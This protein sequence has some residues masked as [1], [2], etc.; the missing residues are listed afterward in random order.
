MDSMTGFATRRGGNGVFEWT[1]DLRSVNGKGL[2]LRLRVPD[3]VTGL[4]QGLRKKLQSALARGSVQ[5]S[6][7]VSK[8]AAD[9]P[10]VLDHTALE[11]IFA[12]STL[13][14]AEAGKRDIPIAPLSV[15]EIWGRLGTSDTNLNE[16]QVKALLARLLADADGLIADLKAMRSTEGA[17]LQGILSGQLDQ[18]TTLMD[19]ARTSLGGRKEEQAQILH[20]ALARLETTNVEPD[21]LA[22]ELALLAV[23]SDV[24]EELDRLDGHVAAARDMVSKNQ[25]VGRKLDFLM[26]EFNRE[27]NTLCSKSANGPLTQTG[28]EMKVLVDQMREQIQN[29]E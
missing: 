21:R 10:A 19:A 14:Q 7:R 28:L 22:Q 24:A 8:A 20:A 25:P 29:V 18:F 1:W 6:L 15:A 27:V 17:A 3:W 2:D 11:N 16:D 5:L 23:K 9:G 12:I 4:D 26:Q 13:I